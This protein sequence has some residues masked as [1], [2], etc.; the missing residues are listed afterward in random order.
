M[1]ASVDITGMTFGHLTVLHRAGSN[2]H[3]MATWMC[4]CGCDNG[5]IVIVTTNALKTGHTKSCGCSRRDCGIRQL[6][7][8]HTTKRQQSLTYKSWASMLQRCE[9][10][11]NPAYDSYGGRGIV[12][13]E[14]WRI[15]DNFLDDMGTRP[16]GTTIDRRNGDLGYYLENCR[17]APSIV[18]VRNRRTVKLNEVSADLIKYMRRRGSLLDDIAH[19]F[20]V[21]SQVISSIA[22]GKMWNPIGFAS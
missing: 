16:H 22:R 15:F 18:Q 2:Q 5:T 8:G 9:N 10:D 6:R 3:K 13:C 14:R 20:G 1:S 21:S 7:H 19:A 4:R 11:R 12:V 17:W